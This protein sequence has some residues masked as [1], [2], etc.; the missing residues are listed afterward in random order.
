MI[1]AVAT[2]PPGGV[3][4]H[5]VGGRDRT[6]QIAMLLL[7]FAGVKSEDIAADYALS[8][9][10]L[11][12]RYAALGEPDQGPELE[13]FLAARATSAGE[14]IVDTLASVDLATTLRRGGLR[15]SDVAAVR[16][17][18]LLGDTDGFRA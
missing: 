4:F 15:A 3:L 5:C 16:E 9:A 2:A 7:A 18:V 13:E 14:L 12:Y 8:S 10:R 1:A 11:T 6:G 17:R